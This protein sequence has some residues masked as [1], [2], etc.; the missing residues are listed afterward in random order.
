MP[1]RFSTKTVIVSALLAF[2]LAQ[3]ASR[4]AQAMSSNVRSVLVAGGYGMLA[5]TALGAATVPFSRDLRTL[6]IGTSMGLYF[7]LALGIYYVA[8]RDDARRVMDS[9]AADAPGSPERPE[10]PERNEARLR[11]LAWAR[12]PGGFEQAAALGGPRMQFKVLEF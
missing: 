6:F 12:S 3:A 8:F 4:P 10:R 1:S 5:G 9:A 2:G 11:E 7:G